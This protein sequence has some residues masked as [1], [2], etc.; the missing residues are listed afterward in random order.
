MANMAYSF[1][2]CKG[3]VEKLKDV[4]G[5]ATLHSKWHPEGIR[6]EHVLDYS[7]CCP[8]E[9]EK[10]KAK[11]LEVGVLNFAD[12]TRRDYTKEEEAELSLWPLYVEDENCVSWQCRY[13]ENDD[14]AFYIS[15]YLPT[16]KLHL[17]IAYEGFDESETWI[18][19][20][21]VFKEETK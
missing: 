14:P 7:K 1:L 19:N 21:K 18:V 15:A 5:P 2:E 3:L 13:V 6:Y 16:E 11:I 4:V 10:Q 20:G 17:H 8:E 12:N 9:W